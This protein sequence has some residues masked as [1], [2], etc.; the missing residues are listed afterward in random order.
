M[1]RLL[2]SWMSCGSALLALTLML[3]CSEKPKTDATPPTVDKSAEGEKPAADTPVSA[4]ATPEQDAKEEMKDE[5]K[6][7][8]PDA[9]DSAAAPTENLDV[10]PEPELGL[11]KPE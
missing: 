2:T 9:A 3:G 1:R 5:E 10:P 7:A 8:G 11:K 6:A 4:D